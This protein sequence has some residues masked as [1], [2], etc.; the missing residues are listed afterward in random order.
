M[1]S[2]NSSPAQS[3]AAA[4]RVS[5][6][7]SR[8]NFH[9]GI[10]PRI[11]FPPPTAPGTVN[12]DSLIRSTIGVTVR[13]CKLSVE[14]IADAMSTLL[15]TRITA[16]MLYSYSA[17]SMEANRLP[18]AWVRAFCQATGDYRL[19][20]CAAEAAGLVF[21]EAEDRVLLELGREYLRQKRAAEKLQSLE[22][23]LAGVEL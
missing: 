3:A 12:D 19:L 4:S 1:T 21:I 7:N 23:T 22:Q 8:G 15:D 2:G 9:E 14:Q 16:K 10:Q 6:G 5:L 11:P 20:R 17:S 18:A 13:R